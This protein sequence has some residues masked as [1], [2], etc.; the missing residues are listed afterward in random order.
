MFS[1]ILPPVDAG[2]LSQRLWEE[3]RIEA[4]VGPWKGQVRMRVSFQAYNDQADADTLVEA[5]AQLLPELGA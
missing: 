1:A 4:P 3:Y 2:R 5:L